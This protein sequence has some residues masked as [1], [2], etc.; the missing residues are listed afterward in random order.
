MS[1]KNT[2]LGGEDLPAKKENKKLPKKSS[3]KPQRKN[4]SAFPLLR[5]KPEHDKAV[6]SHKRSKQKLSAEKESTSKKSRNEEREAHHA[7]RK[8]FYWWKDIPEGYE[9][10]SKDTSPRR[11]KTQQPKPRTPDYDM[12]KIKN[13]GAAKGAATSLATDV[14]LNKFIANAGVCSR[15][16]ADKLIASGRVAVN[17]KVITEMGYR[18]KPSDRVEL[19]GEVLKRER[20]V[21]VL[22][23]KPK[24]YITTTDD[25]QERKTV[26]ELVADACQERIYPVGRLDRNTTGLLLLTND[27]ALAEKLSHPS[28]QVKKNYQL[29]LDKPLEESHFDQIVSGIQLED[30]FI[31]PDKMYYM[32]DDRKII[33]ID[34]HSGRNRIVRRIFEH[35]GYQVVRLDRA[36]Y[37]GLTKKGLPRG[38]WRYLTQQE[39]IRLKYFT[40]KAKKAE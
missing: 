15:R 25:P 7:Q 40:G 23:N 20:L 22:L 2:K 14:R 38:H 34:I 17:G 27:G 18:V 13:I 31:K 29:E 4:S 33:S 30:G 28:N 8:N 39:V 37:A 32:T 3:K 5:G 12:S 10:N 1:K 16:E 21:Y 19:D 35:F 11:R 36:V 26:M 9:R 24:D 6:T